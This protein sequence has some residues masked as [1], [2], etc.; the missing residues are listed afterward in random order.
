MENA[1][2]QSMTKTSRKLDSWEVIMTT[3]SKV[4]K[5]SAVLAVLAALVNIGAGFMLDIR[6]SKSSHYHKK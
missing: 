3:S 6:E 2:K 4:I 1:N 5:Y